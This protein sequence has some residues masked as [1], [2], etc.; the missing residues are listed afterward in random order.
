MA[1][2]LDLQLAVLKIEINSANPSETWL[3]LAGKL[4]DD[5]L[6]E[7]ER[8]LDEA[9]SSGRR[10][11]LDL[12]AVTLADRASVAFLADSGVELARCPGF[13]REWI[14]RELEICRDLG[15]REAAPEGQGER[16]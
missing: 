15:S 4:S 14:R 6:P 7:L 12:A 16:V 3:R 8:L 11:G 1:R 10:V 9:Q 2:L 13:L 5:H